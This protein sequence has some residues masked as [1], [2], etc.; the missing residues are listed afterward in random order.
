MSDQMD[1]LEEKILKHS[2]FKIEAVS[3]SLFISLVKYF[4]FKRKKGVLLVAFWL[5]LTNAG[6]EMAV[7]QL[8]IS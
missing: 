2:C 4:S 3:S 5:C 1:L 8:L 7:V 6:G